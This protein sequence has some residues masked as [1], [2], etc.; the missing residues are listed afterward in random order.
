MNNEFKK[1]QSNN[2]TRYV[3]ESGT[4]GG[5]DSGAVAN[6]PSAGFKNGVVQRRVP[7]QVVTQEAEKEKLPQKPRQ[8]PLRPQTGGGKHTD[9]TKVIPRKYKYPEKFEE[10]KPIST[11]QKL[12][13]RLKKHRAD[14]EQDIKFQQTQQ[15][16][17]AAMQRLSKPDIVKSNVDEN[18]GGEANL[19]IPA[20]GPNEKLN[21]GSRRS[22]DSDFLSW[23]TV[24]G[25]IPVDREHLNDLKNYLAQLEVNAGYSVA[26]DY[27][28]SPMRPRQSAKEKALRK[29]PK[30]KANIAKI[31]QA[32][33]DNTEQ[34]VAEGLHP[35]V[36]DDIKKLATLNPAG[37]YSAYGHIRG[38]FKDNPELSKMASDLMG[39]YYEADMLRGK[40]KT[41]AAKAKYAELEPMHQAFIKQA[42]GQEQG[43][44]EGKANNDLRDNVLAVLT[45]I[46]NGSVAGEYMIDDIADELNDYFDQVQQSND[47][48]LQKAY[49]F[50]VDNGQEAEDNPKLMAR[51]AQKAISLLSQQGVAEGL[52]NPAQEQI[53]QI[54][55]SQAPNGNYEDDRYLDWIIGPESIQRLVQQTKLPLNQVRNYV[56]AFCQ[57]PNPEGVA[58]GANI[59]YTVLVVDPETYEK[60]ELDI[61]ALTQYHAREQ[62]E[63]QGYKVLKVKDTYGTDETGVA[64]VTGDKPFDNMMKNISK[65]TKKQATADRREQKSQNKEQSRA[66]FGNMFG[67]DNP[68]GNLKI[69]ES[70]VAEGLH[71]MVIDDIKK[72]A[73]LNPADRYSAYGNIR[74]YF[75]ADPELSKM[76]SALQGGYYEADML[77]GKYKTAAAKAK[78]DELEPMH[79]AFIKQALGQEQGVA[80]DGE[81]TPEGLPHLTPELL[82]H[83]VQQ[84][85]TDGVQALIKSLKWGDGAAVELLDLITQDLKDKIR[86]KEASN[87]GYGMGGY[88]TYMR[89]K[90]IP[91][92]VESDSYIAELN[93]RLAE[94]IPKNAPV[95][96]WIKDFEKSNAPQFRGKN[97]EKRRQMAVA[98]SYGAKNPS[99]KKK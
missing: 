81:G 32:G 83:I 78:Y 21:R 62:A 7:G 87:E 60:K 36:I 75:K 40:Y 68:T 89:G 8:G 80:E 13:N 55:R 33:D 26:N 86:M 23:R 34:G 92:N 14:A 66:A 94:K 41:D 5:T 64:E 88:E 63:A 61:S 1:L 24:N 54:L 10:T 97:K 73:T 74:G 35:M 98:A 67:G 65:G 39:G 93:A 30:V 6:N 82:K 12:N 91:E 31:E 58:E 38:Y 17:A 25:Y 53:N 49:S 51:I 84:I 71:P 29:I 16:L 72:L 22:G 28:D 59:A 4:G 70:G 79:Q 47:P 19:P 20:P 43:V 77:R 37:R 69:R 44:A 76:A 95:D 85:G 18:T 46:Y 27:S 11:Q 57:N 48:I 45:N 15:A 9:Q 90:G 99:K 42:L 3:L 50:M 56:T 96:V 2:E 52:Q